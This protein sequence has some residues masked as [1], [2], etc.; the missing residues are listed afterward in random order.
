[1]RMRQM[2]G[3]VAVPAANTGLGLLMWSGMTTALLQLRPDGASTLHQLQ[4]LG[5]LA[6][7]LL[8]SAGLLMQRSARRAAPRWPRRVWLLATGTLA[9]ALV[10]GVLLATGAWMTAGPALVAAGVVLLLAAFATVAAIASGFATPAAPAPWRQPL[11]LPVQL[12]FAMAT[13]L[14]LL[15]LL[16]DR[17]FVSGSDGR[18]M[19]ATLTGLGACL[20][21]CK[22][23][24]WRAVGRP[25]D[26]AV[27][28]ARCVVIALVAGAPL[29]AW[30]LAL[31][32]R[33]PGVVLLL[34][35]A[36]ALLGAALL[37]HRVFLDEGNARDAGH[38]S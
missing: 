33:V 3:I 14:A 23:V 27:R 22:L 21:V 31:W 4:L 20:A 12:L 26:A 29:L 18:T 17:L 36:L 9:I 37:E 6:G 30:L 15:Y 16:M 13:G 5:L 25:P 2:L 10:L 35:S 1:M 24:Y 28:R 8:L 34:G 38:E 19:L 32:G 7:G 11:V